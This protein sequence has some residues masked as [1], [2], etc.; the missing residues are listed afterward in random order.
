MAAANARAAA[1]G[2]PNGP[3]AT[4]GILDDVAVGFNPAS[5]SFIPLAD[6]VIRAVF[7]LANFRTNGKEQFGADGVIELLGTRA[8][9]RRGT[10]TPKGGKLF[11]TLYDLALLER[12]TALATSTAHAG[13]A[14]P[15]GW[16]ESLAGSL[17]WVGST[18]DWRLRLHRQGLHAAVAWAR[19]RQYPEVRLSASPGQLSFPASLMAGDVTF[20]LNHARERRWRPTQFFDAGRLR[21]V[22][23]FCAR[24]TS[25]PLPSGEGAVQ[26]RVERAVMGAGGR[27]VVGIVSD[28]SIDAGAWGSS[29]WA[30]HVPPLGTGSE[31]GE[32]SAP[33]VAGDV[34][35]R[36]VPRGATDD[37][38]T[39]ELQPWVA[40]L[41][42]YGEQLRGKFLVMTGD[43]FGNMYRV[44]R[45]RVRRNTPAYPLL[46]R[47]YDLA[48]HYDVDFLAL[49]LPRAANQL[50][51]SISKCR[52]YEEAA[53]ACPP[54][55][56]LVPAPA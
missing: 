20:V 8:D 52:S 43:N 1:E 2:K 31:G 45:G 6:R 18:F 3:V 25:A 27:E 32:A 50:L 21:V 7:K 55:V 13:L 44:N 28:A 10:L 15:R 34:L 23:V 47:L 16:L 33:D 53:R 46:Q 29:V 37:S 11:S 17:E 39:I 19:E 48:A 30:V 5:P 42:R 41:E 38:G 54:G 36:S 56:R 22:R 35:F 9:L 51:D 4:A 14:V 26:A 40:V 49:W 12:L 24:C